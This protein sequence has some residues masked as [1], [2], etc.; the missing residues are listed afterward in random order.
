[1]RTILIAVM[2]LIAGPAMAAK[3][4]V[5]VNI[6]SDC[7]LRINAECYEL[8]GKKSII[9]IEASGVVNVVV[10]SDVFGDLITTSGNQ[11]VFGGVGGNITNNSGDV[12]L[13]RVPK[14]LSMLGD[15]NVNDFA[16]VSA[17]A[18]ANNMRLLDRTG[19]LCEWRITP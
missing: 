1:M 13:H 17:G 6:G 7:Q 16:T 15:G 14:N 19:K 12:V 4:L 9:D 2:C 18:A 3:H 8:P 11:T 10:N 5:P